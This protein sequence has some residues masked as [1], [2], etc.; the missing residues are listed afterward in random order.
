[1]ETTQEDITSSRPSE[2]RLGTPEGASLVEDIKKAVFAEFDRALLAGTATREEVELQKKHAEAVAELSSRSIEI[3]V[4]EGILLSETQKQ[5]C[6]IYAYL[7]DALKI[8]PERE[9]VSFSTEIIE[10]KRR[11]SEIESR[12]QSRPSGSNAPK[13]IE[14]LSELKARKDELDEFQDESATHSGH[15]T[16][17]TRLLLHGEDSALW[18]EQLLADL[19]FSDKFIEKTKLDLITHMPMPYVTAALKESK[20]T[21]SAAYSEA[22]QALEGAALG[23]RRGNTELVERGKAQAQSYLRQADS[24]LLPEQLDEYGEF[25]QPQT[26]EG[27][28]LY[29][30]DLISPT[31][32]AGENIDAN[33]TAGCFDRYLKINLAIAYGTGLNFK[34]V[35]EAALAGPVP[36]INRLNNPPAEEDRPEAAQIERILGEKLG[37]PALRKLLGFA[38]FIESGITINGEPMRRLEDLSV[39][40]QELKK[41]GIDAMLPRETLDK[42]YQTVAAYRIA[43][44]LDPSEILER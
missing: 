22:A 39:W 26:V 6:Q 12:L 38:K 14:E 18:A 4:S 10:I 13:L 11:I 43:K 1:M 5:T 32:M 8:V 36:N 25:I 3:L 41:E 27:A 29:A 19:G 9:N 33:P 40:N 7:H 17:T 16:R 37:G 30:A 28:V 20:D 21:K 44:E 24:L 31:I 35:F 23:A 42:Y 15:F 34:D 2:E